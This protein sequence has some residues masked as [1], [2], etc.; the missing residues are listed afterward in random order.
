MTASDAPP[1]R[2]TVQP[3]SL[4]GQS[5]RSGAFAAGLGL[6]AGVL[7]SSICAPVSA[8]D[9]PPNASVVIQDQQPL[10]VKLFGAGVGN[11][12][13]YGSGIIVSPEGH[14]V[15]VWN[16]L[17]N[18][19]YLNAVT[20]DGQ[21]YSVSVVGTS[22]DFDLAVLKLNAT[23]GRRFKFVDLNDAVDLDAGASVLAFSN[24]FHV[25]TGNEPV[26]VVH[27]TIAARTEL[28]ALQGR[29]QFPVKSPVL[30]IDAITNNSGATGGLLTTLSGR[31]VGLLGR[32]IRHQQSNTWVNYAV[33]L[34]TLKSAIESLIAGKRIETESAEESTRQMISDRELTRRFGLTLL[35]PVLERTP[36]YVDSVVSNSVTSKAG[37]QRGD[38]IVLL[39][40]SVITSVTDFRQRLAELRSGQPINITVSRNQQLHTI[41]FR[42]P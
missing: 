22:R 12:D 15:T 37:M 21:R 25:A 2:P 28:Q 6:L 29:W 3:D 27:G 18:V 24:M 19:G 26:S 9:T 36:A 20:S 35:P 39:N 13:S 23:E 31:P 7:A 4:T 1:G 34:T 10:I 33:P 17:I 40:D 41:E 16:H 38:L 30:I 11:L 8:L 32:E 14:V 5:F 42:N